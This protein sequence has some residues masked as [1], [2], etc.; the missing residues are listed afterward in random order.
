VRARPARA[1]ALGVD[2]C[3]VLTRLRRPA[4]GGGRPGAGCWAQLAPCGRRVRGAAGGPARGGGGGRGAVS[5][6]A[7][8]RR[9]RRG[10]R[11]R[12]RAAAQRLCPRVA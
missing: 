2:A 7:A 9:G 6:A 1:R 4:R 11:S 8:R 5:A 12:R 3:C 10:G